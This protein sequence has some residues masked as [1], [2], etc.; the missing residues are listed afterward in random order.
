ML[1]APKDGKI[2]HQQSDAYV[3]KMFWEEVEDELAANGDT[4][5]ATFCRLL[6]EWHEAED[7]PGLKSIERCKLKTEKNGC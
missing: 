3:R 4:K 7:M 5:E 6:R 2:M 1:E